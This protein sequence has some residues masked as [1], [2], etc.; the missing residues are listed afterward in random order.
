MQNYLV[1]TS[2]NNSLYPIA[3]ELEFEHVACL[4][5]HIYISKF[6]SNI[7]DILLKSESYDIKN[8]IQKW[9]IKGIIAS[10]IFFLSALGEP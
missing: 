10:K 7:D 1:I 5:I 6:K 2:P 3:F 9:V 4:Y 8:N